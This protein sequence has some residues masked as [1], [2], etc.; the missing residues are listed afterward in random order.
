MKTFQSAA[1][2]VQIKPIQ[3]KYAAPLF[4]AIVDS[5]PAIGDFLPWAMD[6]SLKDEKDFLLREKN[7]QFE[8][9]PLVFALVVAGQPVGMLDLHAVNEAKRSAEIGYWISQQYQNQ[10]IVSRA[11][12]LISEHAL[13]RLA[14]GRLVL[15][16][17][18]ENQASRRVAEKAGFI[19]TG[20]V[21]DF[22]CY[23]R[24]Q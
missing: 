6:L 22:L 1:G 21:D 5:R 12:E 4:Q 20:L 17:K 23:E 19:E 14:L 18:E 7:R 24:C 8:G 9:Q 2:L 10:G 16:I 11:V 13:T 15:R 3:V